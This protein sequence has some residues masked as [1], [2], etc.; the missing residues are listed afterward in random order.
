MKKT[1]QPILDVD[2]IGDQDAPITSEEL[3]VISDYFQ[4]KKA[5]KLTA[6]K[7]KLGAAA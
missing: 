6:K 5:K 2:F 3:K 1:V 4:Q 7:A